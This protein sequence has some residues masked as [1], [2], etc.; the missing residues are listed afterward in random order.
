MIIKHAHVSSSSS[1][2]ERSNNCNG[3]NKNSVFVLPKPLN[4]NYA[5]GNLDY[6][7]RFINFILATNLGVD[8]EETIV[9]EEK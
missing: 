9:S 3:D 4:Y 6:G 8:K 2:C 5:H 7:E 1:I